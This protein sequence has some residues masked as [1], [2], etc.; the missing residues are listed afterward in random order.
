MTAH[1]AIATGGDLPGRFAG[2]V[3]VVTGAAQ[4][5]GRAVA[6][7][8]AAEGGK[9]VAGR[10]VGDRPRGRRS[11]RPAALPLAVDADLETF[12][13]ADSGHGAG[14]RAASAGID[15]LINNVGG[16]IWAK[17]YRAITTERRSR[18]RSAARCSRRCGAAARCCR[19]C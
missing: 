16:T 1:A 19:P 14:A 6:E 12:A 7:R 13:G 4:G 17:P 18:P 3:V 10:P 2:K 5:I 8:L 15:I 9:V 11:W